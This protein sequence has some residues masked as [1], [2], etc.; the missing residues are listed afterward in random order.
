MR[1]NGDG[2]GEGEGDDDDKTG[3]G[4]EDPSQIPAISGPAVA[5]GAGKAI[6]QSSIADDTEAS[7]LSRW[8]G[9]D[10]APGTWR[11]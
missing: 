9:V 6:V 4:E 7:A 3:N 11:E 8:D 10:G 1:E 2:E 5:F